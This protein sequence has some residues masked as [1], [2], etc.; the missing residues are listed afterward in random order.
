MIA[1]E[2]SSDTKT[3][4]IIFSNGVKVCGILTGQPNVTPSKSTVSVEFKVLSIKYEFQT[5]ISCIWA[6]RTFPI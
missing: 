1:G 3:S 4:T 6:D 5:A 2:P